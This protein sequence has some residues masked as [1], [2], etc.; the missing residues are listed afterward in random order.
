MAGKS[1]FPLKIADGLQIGTV[2]ELKEHLGLAASDRVAFTQEEL[3]GLLDMNADVIYLYGKRFT[4]PGSI[5]GITY[6]GINNPMVKF[7]GEAVE[8]GIDLQG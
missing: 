7:D 1:R 3:I 8:P 2:A 4:I 6:I 5:Q